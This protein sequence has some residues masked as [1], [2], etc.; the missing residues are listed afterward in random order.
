[1]AEDGRGAVH[2]TAGAPQSLRTRGPADRPRGSSK[3]KRSREA[4]KTSGSKQKKA[5]KS[6]AHAY[7][8]YEGDAAITKLRKHGAKE[9]WLVEVYPAKGFEHERWFMKVQ[10][11]STY[12]SAEGDTMI[13]ELVWL[14]EGS[15]TKANKKFT[16]ESLD[17][18]MA[19]AYGEPG[20]FTLD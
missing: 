13:T 18:M 10:D 11:G 2:S 14:E 3:G 9:G 8:G 16:P 4:E 5:K 6:T 17:V 20:Y 15:L 19:R 12:K 1:V 7:K